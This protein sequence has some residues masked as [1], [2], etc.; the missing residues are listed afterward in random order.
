MPNPGNCWGI[1]RNPYYWYDYEQKTC[2]FFSSCGVPGTEGKQNFFYDE[3]ECNTICASVH[4]VK[5]K[6]C[7][8]DWGQSNINGDLEGDFKWAFNTHEANC[9]IYEKHAGYPTP[10]LFNSWFECRD[11]CYDKDDKDE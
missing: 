8:I 10:L 1:F 6:D 4:T 7:L 11:S 2:K 5:T 3:D 9:K